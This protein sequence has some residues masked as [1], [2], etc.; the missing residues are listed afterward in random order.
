[1]SEHLTPDLKIVALGG[2][3]GLSASLRALKRLTPHLT[4]V[5]GVS[6]NGGSSGRL[7]E[8]FDVIPPGDLR[9]A[10]TALCDD[11]TGTMWADVLQHRFDGRGPLGGHALGN[12]LITA[13]WQQ[14]GDIVSGLDAVSQLLNAQGRVLPLAL[15]PL[16]V[17]ATVDFGDGDFQEVRGQVAVAKAPGNVVDLKLE[18]ASPTLCP[19]TMAAIAEA[20]VIVMGPG[21]WFTSVMNHLV[22]PSMANALGESPARKFLVANLVT[23]AGETSGL[24]TA[25][26]LDAIAA[27]GSNLSFEAVFLH[28]ALVDPEVQASAQI[29]GAQVVSAPLADKSNPQVHDPEA[30]AQLLATYLM[31]GR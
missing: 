17:V 4:A 18:P 27:H 9:M 3:H 19:E 25:A 16:D 12:L 31:D 20:D 30:L 7:R 5:V 2:G 28:E 21:S 24:S 22:L 11:E 6:D 14:Q 13:L 1:M 15:Q 23:Q 29:L 26:H 8:E 10:L